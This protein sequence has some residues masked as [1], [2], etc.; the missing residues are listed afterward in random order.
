MA[1]LKVPK[2]VQPTLPSRLCGKQKGAVHIE[3]DTFGDRF[4][5]I[6]HRRKYTIDQ[7]RA[8]LL[9]DKREYKEHW[10]AL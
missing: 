2:N 8:S 5:L 6:F 3:K 7:G 9:L 10:K 1:W 4:T